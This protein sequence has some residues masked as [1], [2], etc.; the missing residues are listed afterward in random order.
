MTDLYSSEDHGRGEVS[1]CSLAAISVCNIDTDEEY[2]EATYYALKMI[3]KCIHL[4]DYPL[5]HMAVTVKSR[6]NAGVG[7]IGLATCLARAG[8]TYSSKEGKQLIHDLAE[9]HAYFVIKSSLRLGKELGNAPWINRTKWPSGWLPIDTYKK[10]VDQIIPSNYKYDWESLRKEIIDNGG[11]RNSSLMTH[12]PTES[13]SKAS[14]VPNGV[15]PIRGS[16]LKK[17]DGSNVIDWCAT[18][19]DLLEGKYDIAWNIP[20][21]D[22]IE[23]YAIIQKFTDQ[24]ISADF[25][26]D[27]SSNL[28]ITDEE[29]I[30]DYLH[31][32]KFGMKTRYY[33]NSLTSNQEEVLNETEF[34]AGCDSGACSL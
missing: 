19:S 18:D 29:M 25:Y 27:R 8:Y 14:G 32:V 24:A 5:P 13:S 15:Y 26:R 30:S 6:L 34:K 12:M 3:D 1:T 22:M 4:S 7:M 28:D 23:C 16:S 17:K 20:T 11:I 9:R 31:M 2:E 21:K 33:Q 10:T